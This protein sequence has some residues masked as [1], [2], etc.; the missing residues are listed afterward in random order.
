MF[1]KSRPDEDP[2]WSKHVAEWVLYIVVFGGCLFPVA[3]SV[4][5]MVQVTCTGGGNCLWIGGCKM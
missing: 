3:R 5:G 2:T 4:T 1:S